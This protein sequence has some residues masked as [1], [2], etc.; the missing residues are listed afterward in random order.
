MKNQR[1]PIAGLG[2]VRNARA[3]RNPR[4]AYSVKCASF[5]VMKWTINSVSGVVFG[6]NQSMSGPIMRDVFPAEKLPEEAKE[7]KASQAIS[8]K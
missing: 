5:L 6:N 4:I 1:P 3:A 2:D 7:M 8:G